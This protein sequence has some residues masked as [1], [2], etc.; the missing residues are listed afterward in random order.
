LMVFG[1]SPITDN[2]DCMVNC[3]SSLMTAVAVFL[4]HDT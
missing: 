2:S 3:S 4:S 1:V